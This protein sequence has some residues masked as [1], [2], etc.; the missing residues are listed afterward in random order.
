MHHAIT[1]LMGV[2]NVNKVKFTKFFLLPRLKLK[3]NFFF[4]FFLLLILV[5]ESVIVWCNNPTHCTKSKNEHSFF[6]K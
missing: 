6:N 5:M 1:I 2:K 3:V 4:F